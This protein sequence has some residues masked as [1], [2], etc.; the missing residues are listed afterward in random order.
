VTA[1][2]LSAI[3]DGIPPPELSVT[4][5][6]LAA[7]VVVPL[8]C[9]KTPDPAPPEGA[10]SPSFALGPPP[11]DRFQTLRAGDKPLLPH[12]KT[13]WEVDLERRAALAH[14]SGMRNIDIYDDFRKL[15]IG[16]FY[17]TKPPQTAGIRV[18]AEYEPSQAYLLNWATFSTADWN[19][20]FGAIVKGAWGIV[21]VLMIHTDAAHRTWI[22]QQIQGLGIPAA[23]LGDPTKIIWWQHETD[24]IWA[25]DYGPV[26]I[27][28]TPPSGT[29]TLSFVDFRYYHARPHDDQTPASLAKDWGV[30]DFRAD[31]DFEGGN[32]MSTSDGLCGA[33]KGVL[34][35]NLALTQ[36]AIEQIFAQYLGC[37]KTIF[38][39][40]M[41][42]GVIAH[43]DMFSKFASDT[44]VMVGEYT[45]AQDP[46]NKAIL[47]ANATL[48][49]ATTNGKGQSMTVV[50]IPM[51][52]HVGLLGLNVWRTYTNSLALSNGTQKVLLIPTYADET[53]YESAAMAA[54]ATAFPG[55]T[56]IKID[57]MVI[58]PG[59][60]AIHCITMQIPQGSRAKM[61]SD[62]PDLCGTT[63]SDC[64]PEIC[65]NITPTG[66]C[67]GQILKYCTKGAL[68]YTECS[69]T[70]QCGWDGAKGY[71]SC[72]TAGGPDP[73]GKQARSCDVLTDAALPDTGGCGKLTIEGCCDGQT[74]QFCQN[75]VLRSQDCSGTPSCGWSPIVGAYQCGTSGGAELTG[76][77]PKVCGADGGVVVDAQKIDRQTL[78]Q[79]PPDRSA[80]RVVDRAPSPDRATA[81]RAVHDRAVAEHGD[82]QLVLSGTGCGCGVTR[83][84]PPPLAPLALVAL[85]VLVRWRRRR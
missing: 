70:P 46:T 68:K 80:D 9:V 35:Y 6:W 32:F 66:C 36:S 45:T 15:N 63:T 17:I 59:Q 65:G 41:K 52:G 50:R 33:T 20:L 31:L 34:Y 5:C 44:V 2:G 71:Y 10:T 49:A 47:D 21:P 56:L 78:D 39:A 85:A 67:A 22:E 42:G 79:R 37:K 30:N 74:L 77:F 23:Q 81:D 82:G 8:A 73:S 27:V 19:A 26:S 16:D 40:T 53:T 84:S 38:P 72:G 1:A 55:W 14:V 3:V 43:I 83:R 61:E 48:Y 18:P 25:R 69:S 57:S 29:G 60:G 28:T 7:L 75:G 51:P 62:P 13:Q 76:K 4:R 24:A 64:T 58:I 54:Y 11:A 12:F